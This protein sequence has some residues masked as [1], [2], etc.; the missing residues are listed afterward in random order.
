M[1]S[2]ENID[3]VIS[4][5]IKNEPDVKWSYTKVNEN[6]LGTDVQEK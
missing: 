4:T 1:L 2:N 3:G 5:F 6:G